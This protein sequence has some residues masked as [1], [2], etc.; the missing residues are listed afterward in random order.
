VAI[1]YFLW[2]DWQ[3]AKVYDL[4]RIL[5]ADHDALKKPNSPLWGGYGVAHYWGEPLYGYYRS[6]DPWVLR[7]HAAL[8][9]DAGI[10]TLI[11]DA[12]NAVTYRNTYMK[13]CEEFAA[14]RRAGGHTPQIAFMVNTAA[15]KTAETI[16]RDLY[17]PKLYSELWFRWQGKPLMICD[18]KD[19]SPELRAF[20]TLRRAH[21]PFEMV[22]TA[23]AW[24]WEATYPQPYGYSGDP[25]K[26]EQV[27]VAVAQNLRISD[28]KATCMSD[29]NAR[30]R[31][32]HDG[33][34]D[35]SPG[36]IDRGLNFQ[37]QWRRAFALDPPVVMVTGWNEWVAGR[38][39]DHGPLTF[40]DQFTE[41]YSRDI[42]PMHG[43]HGDNYYYQ[44]VANVR[45]YKGAVPLPPASGA[46]TIHIEQG[47]DQWRDVGPEFAGHVGLTSPRDHAGAYGTHYT[48]R[49]GRNNLALMK[50][51]RDEQNFYFYVRT[52]APIVPATDAAGLW[53]LIDSDRNPRTG[54][55]G[56]DFIVNR[57]AGWLE[58]NAGGWNWKKVAKVTCRI[59][60]SE[61]HLAVP[62]AALGRPGTFDFKWVD[63]LQ[64]P[65]NVMDF[66]L[67]GDAAPPG[68]FNFR[69]SFER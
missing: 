51:A 19:V 28:G 10:D 50:V 18:P 40:V 16:Y 66:Y 46:K 33:R 13:L 38:F 64:R 44:L 17:K 27:N 14:V 52:A 42:E 45:R 69:Y 53:L 63:N 54:W 59:A 67:S 22:N 62:R 23:D 49:T 48:D 61:M 37:E 47:F 58:S 65:G 5:A 43:G 15:G 12:T 24:H 55:A 6:D 35:T 3:G 8:L 11:F 25:G 57:E 29:G 1:F 9:A 32:F 34:E 30:G 20:F 56:Y 39:P 7:R 41:E 60:G 68:R 2:H 36:A 4:S 26:P 31:S 21:W